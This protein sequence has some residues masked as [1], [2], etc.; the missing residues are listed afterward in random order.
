MLVAKCISKI[1]SFIGGK[2]DQELTSDRIRGSV[3][4]LSR[5]NLRLALQ[6]GLY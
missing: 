1:Y 5:V 2:M 6:N 4:G 3:I